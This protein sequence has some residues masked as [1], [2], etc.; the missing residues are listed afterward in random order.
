M[1]NTF[2]ISISNR[3]GATSGEEN[4]LNMHIPFFHSKYYC[5]SIA[6]SWEEKF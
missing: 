5:M 6:A 3:T 1:N 2:H 4:G